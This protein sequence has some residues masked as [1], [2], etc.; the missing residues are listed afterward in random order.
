[1]FAPVFSRVSRSFSRYFSSKS[2]VN[3]YNDAQRHARRPCHQVWIRPRGPG[4]DSRQVRPGARCAAPLV[5]QPSHRLP[6]RALRRRCVPLPGAA[7]RIHPLQAGERPRAGRGQARQ[8]VDDGVQADG[9][10]L[11]L[12]RLRRATH[13]EERTVPDCGSL[14]GAG[15]ERD[16]DVPG[17]AGPQGRQVR[18]VRTRTQ[19]GAGSGPQLDGR[20]AQCRPGHH[21]TPDGIQQGR[22]RLGHQHGQHSSHV[23]AR[24][25]PPIDQ[26][27]NR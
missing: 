11:L 10:H 6:D 3:R 4:Q 24:E 7:R 23:S 2:P 27:I 20:T 22:Q 9:E 15:P 12:P 17:R 5:G 13:Y 1:L 16:R 26:S 25:R 21:R 14:R 8:H 19:G 18:Q